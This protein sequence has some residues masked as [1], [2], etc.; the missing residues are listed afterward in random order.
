MIKHI[1]NYCGKELDGNNEWNH[2]TCTTH[3][4]YGSKY[5]GDYFRLDL[6]TACTDKFIELVR[7]LC[8]ED[9]LQE[10]NSLY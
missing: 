6:C 1:C 5:D 2:A 4:G 8:K 9:P 7:P 3:L 10:D